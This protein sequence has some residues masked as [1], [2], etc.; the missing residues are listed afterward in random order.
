MNLSA[1]QGAAALTLA[2][3]LYRQHVAES[4][5]HENRFP[6][7]SELDCNQKRAWFDRAETQLGIGVA[8]VTNI[9]PNGVNESTLLKL[10]IS[11]YEKSGI[12]G[13]PVGRKWDDL[14]VSKK[15]KWM[16]IAEENSGVISAQTYIGTKV[17]KGTPMTRG[18][19][20]HLRSWATPAGENPA[21]EG[22]LVECLDGGDSNHPAYE[23]YISWSPK[24]VFEKAYLPAEENMS[25]SQ[26]LELIKSGKQVARAGWNGASQFIYLLP[27]SKLQAAAGYGFG[28]YVG[29]PEFVKTIVLHNAQ[30]KL[31]VGWVPSTGDLFASD[32]KIA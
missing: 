17:V 26:A 7:W 8:I 22:Y 9:T 1:Q 20:N 4:G 3:Q 18:D 29:E 6:A 19:Y 12:G 5:I 32:W 31:V 13:R 11:M 28:E 27:A 10:A 2:V 15:Q 14:P 23:N 25:F 21:D 16:K 24:A 30:G